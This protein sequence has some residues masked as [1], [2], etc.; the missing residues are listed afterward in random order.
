[1]PVLMPGVVRDPGFLNRRI[2]PVAMGRH[3]CPFRVQ[4]RDTAPLRAGAKTLKGGNGGFVQRDVPLPFSRLLSPHRE[5][6]PFEIDIRPAQVPLLGG[7]EPCMERND[8]GREAGRVA[9]GE[10][11]AEASLLLRSEIADAL[12]VLRLA[13]DARG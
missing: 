13:A 2:K 1:M 9:G 3:R 6:L 10:R 5:R 12:I 11:L 4:E 7:S 8:E